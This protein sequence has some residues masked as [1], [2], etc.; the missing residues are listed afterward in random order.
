MK[1]STAPWGWGEGK[2]GKI[3]QRKEKKMVNKRS[4]RKVFRKI[5]LKTIKFAQ[6]GNKKYLQ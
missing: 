4:S 2:G 1:S 6:V 3:V 5:Q